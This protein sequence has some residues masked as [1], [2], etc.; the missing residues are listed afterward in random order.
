MTIRPMP[1]DA[2]TMSTI[3]Q[4]MNSPQDATRACLDIIPD[5]T[6]T[7]F[8]HVAYI[9]AAESLIPAIHH[10]HTHGAVDAN[11][12][13]VPEDEMLH[14]NVPR[15]DDG[16][17]TGAVNLYFLTSLRTIAAW[18][19]QY[20][21]EAEDA[22]YDVAGR[23]AG[24]T[25]RQLFLSRSR[26]ENVKAVQQ[27]LANRLD[28]PRALPTEHLPFAVYHLLEL[29]IEQ[30]DL[31]LDLQQDPSQDQQNGFYFP[32]VHYRDITAYMYFCVLLES[33]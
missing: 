29:L 27:V 6:D 28:H 26:A 12:D 22:E 1:I 18:A 23:L 16:Q 9:H 21:D 24:C 4:L 33:L 31:N 13:R 10:H 15:V 2:K 20:P 25:K 11:G 32:E 19:Q 14:R 5:P 3:L 8:L 7:P 30:A 17:I